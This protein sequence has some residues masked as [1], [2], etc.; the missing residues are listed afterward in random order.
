MNN[1]T[2]KTDQIMKIMYVV[3]GELIPKGS[4]YLEEK[5]T[6]NDKEYYAFLI[7]IDQN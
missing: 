5:Y 4:I 3:A 2:I 1:K 6:R 7:P